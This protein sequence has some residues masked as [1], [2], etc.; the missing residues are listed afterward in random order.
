MTVKNKFKI[1]RATKD[2]EAGFMITPEI[3]VMA[4]NKNVFIAAAKEGL[5]L[6]G[7]LSIVTMGSQVRRGGLFVEQ[8]EWLKMIPSTMVTPIP[9]VLPIPPVALFSTIAKSLPFILAM[10]VA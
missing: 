8:T 4:A 1:W 7:P 6:S 5:F 9:Q 3:A 2:S 10:M